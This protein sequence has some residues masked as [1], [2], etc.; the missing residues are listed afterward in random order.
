MEQYNPSSICPKCR[1]D[2]IATEWTAEYTNQLAIDM[3]SVGGYGPVPELKV[4]FPEYMKRTCFNCKYVW[5][6]TPLDAKETQ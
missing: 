4:L 1:F 5:G 3:L 6:E 2:G